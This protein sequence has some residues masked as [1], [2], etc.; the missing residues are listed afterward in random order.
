MLEVARQLAHYTLRMRGVGHHEQQVI[1]ATMRYYRMG[2]GPRLVILLHGLGDS[3]TNWRAVAHGIQQHAEVIIPD[4][5]GFGRSSLPTGDVFWPHRAYRKALVEFLEPWADRQP[6]IVGNSMG[7]WLSVQMMLDRPDLCQRAI[8]INPG[9]VLVPEPEIARETFREFLATAD[10]RVI[11]AKL[12]HRPPQAIGLLASGI[13]R[14]MR[15]PVV[16]QFLSTIED[17]DILL[18]ADLA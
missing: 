14:Q 1:G 5:P 3:A 17:A 13:E 9:G 10:G 8:L 6:I 7:G 18:P 4:L 2:K 16:Q 12:L 11:L 15:S